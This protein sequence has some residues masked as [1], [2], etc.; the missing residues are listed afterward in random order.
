MTAVRYLVAG[1]LGVG[2][3][4]LLVLQ[5]QNPPAPTVDRVGFPANY[6]TTM[7]VLYVFDRPDNK[8]VRTIYANAPVFTVQHDGSQSN[9]P[10]GS[11]VVMETWASL[12]DADTNPILDANG[13]YQKDPAAMP[14]LFVMR[15]E[16]GFGVDYGPNR[17]GEWEY[18][19]YHPD[20]TYST[21]PPNSF[22]CAIC[23]LQAGQGKDWVFRAAL[24]FNNASGG[25]P[26]A[27]IKNY[28]FVPGTMHVKAGNAITL[29][30]DDVVAHTIVDDS[31]GGYNSGLISAGSSVDLKF[32]NVPFEWDYH[33]SI[34]PAMKGK[35][36]VDP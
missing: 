36:I 34:H 11:V 26:G 9:Y 31:A 30:N 28:Q 1:A 13:R 2:L 35:I 27:V 18:V 20:G 24:H 14:T 16:K 6:K 19:A 23:H 3:M 25:S 22:S 8:Q 7:N 12:K 29:Y 17:N 33:C 10:D 5:A 32:G 4:A 21:T 15:K